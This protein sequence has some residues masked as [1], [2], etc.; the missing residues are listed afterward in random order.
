ALPERIG[1]MGSDGVPVPVPVRIW[2]WLKLQFA[3]DAVPDATATPGW[4]PP[5]RARIWAL[6]LALAGFAL[7]LVPLLD[8]LGFDL[9]FALGLLAAPAAVDVG[10]AVGRRWRAGAIW[11]QSARI[12]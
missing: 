7:G 10:H 6:I 12:W 4:R 3:R 2:S 9:S 1:P 8:V 5:R 11:S